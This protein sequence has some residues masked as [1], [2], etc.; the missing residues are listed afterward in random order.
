MGSYKRTSLNNKSDQ[1]LILTHFV[2]TLED[3]VPIIGLGSVEDPTD[4]SE[5]LKIGASLVGIGRELLREPKWVQK[6][7]SGDEESI[8]KNISYSDM[9]DLRIPKVMQ[10]SLIESFSNV[11][12]FT[13]NTENLEDYS[14][15]M[16]PMEGIEKKL[17]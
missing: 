7:Q 3:S 15:E 8:R 1:K 13:T 9:D 14:K 6:I 5:V 2:E 10:Q 16:A 4:A 17:L 11:M 12:N